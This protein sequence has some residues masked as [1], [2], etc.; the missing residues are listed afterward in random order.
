MSVIAEKIDL[1][2]VVKSSRF[3]FIATPLNLP[4]DPNQMPHYKF[5]FRRALFG[6][7]E[8]KEKQS[9]TVHSANAEMYVQLGEMQKRG[10]PTPMPIVDVYKPSIPD[11]ASEKEVILFLN[12]TSKNE[13]RFAVERSFESI[14]KLPEVER[15]LQKK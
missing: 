9:F 5:S 12:V 15:L 14:K 4:S 3:V 6:E 1:E 13:F 10:E 8:L 2:K 7:T 11:F